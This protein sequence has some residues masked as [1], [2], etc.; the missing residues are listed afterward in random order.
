[1]I[2]RLVTSGVLAAIAGAAMTVAVSSSPLSRSLYHRRPSPTKS[3]KL[4]FSKFTITAAIITAPI[5]ITTTILIITPIIIPTTTI[6]TT[7]LTTT[8]IITIIPTT[9]IA[10]T[11]HIIR[12][13]YHHWRGCW[14]T[15]YRRACAVGTN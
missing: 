11:T 12:P 4:T 15:G 10:I 14:G 9:T 6:T 7:T 3:P 2:P 13:Y 8:T 1:M 5:T